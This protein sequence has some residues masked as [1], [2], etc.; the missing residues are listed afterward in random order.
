M[1]FRLCVRI[2]LSATL[3]TQ[4][5]TTSFSQ[6]QTALPLRLPDGDGAWSIRVTVRG[7]LTRENT[8]YVAVTSLGEIACTTAPNDCRGKLDDSEFTS[9]REL[10]GDLKSIDWAPQ[11][12]EPP[13]CI[14]CNLTSFFLEYREGASVQVR[15]FSWTD[16]TKSK[17]PPSVSKIVDLIRS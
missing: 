2:L 3:L 15:R 5:V 13:A 1:K 17:I 10:I 16:L 11:S 4:Q 7:G 8:G 9:L 6:Q 12:N 14:D